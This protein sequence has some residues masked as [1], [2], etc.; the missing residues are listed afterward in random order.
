MIGS[1][2]LDTATTIEIFN[3]M[4]SQEQLIA[5]M[6]EHMEKLQIVGDIIV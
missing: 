1:I 2:R 4:Q 6:V 3:H 5:S